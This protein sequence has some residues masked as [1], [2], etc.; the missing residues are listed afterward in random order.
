MKIIIIALACLALIPSSAMSE[1]LWSPV[2]DSIDEA[3]VSGLNEAI[4][5]AGT[6][7]EP[8]EYVGIVYQINGKFLF[9]VPQTSSNEHAALED[10][11]F[12]A[13]ATMVA[14]FHNHNP[15]DGNGEFSSIDIRNAIK[16]G[17]PCF[18]AIADENYAVRKFDPSDRGSIHYRR[19]LSNPQTRGEPVSET[20]DV[21]AKR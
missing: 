21:L 3:A 4:Y 13:R 11:Q 9:T 12:P 18:I 16:S 1:F 17:V 6:H 20:G 8:V 19:G 10:I 7:D 15:G 5:M 14:T 2:Y